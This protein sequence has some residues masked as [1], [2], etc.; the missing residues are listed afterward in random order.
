MLKKMLVKEKVQMYIR[1]ATPADSLLL[2]TL[3]MDVQSL[4]ASN[5]PDIFIM[6]ESADFAVPFFNE[7]L[8]DQ[9]ITI[10]IAEENARALGY[11]V[12]KLIERPKNA[13][14][15]ELRYILI[16]QISVKPETRT[17]GIGSKLIQQ[18]EALAREIK[19]SKI[20]LD[21]WDFNASAHTFFE[22]LGF[23]KYNYR[24]W[25]LI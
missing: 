1:K 23:Q 15:F 2:S 14:T 16:D 3:C 4:H 18:A 21:S 7:M 12:C 6:P 19:V 22:N 13:F 25:K 10:F 20:Q 24:F 5:H 8:A 17:Q 11:I 9:A